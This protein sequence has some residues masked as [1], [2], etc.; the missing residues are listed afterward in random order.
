VD[1]NMALFIDCSGCALDELCVA[2]EE[3][4]SGVR[5]QTSGTTFTW[6]FRV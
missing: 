5:F 4:S 3:F 6:W 2:L 1:I